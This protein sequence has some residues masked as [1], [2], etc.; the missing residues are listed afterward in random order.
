MIEIQ[1]NVELARTKYLHSF[2]SLISPEIEVL[3]AALN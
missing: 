3:N 1:E 2:C